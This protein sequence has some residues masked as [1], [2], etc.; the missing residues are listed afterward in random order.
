MS[1]QG[2]YIR[3]PT[4][5]SPL[6]SL[7]PLDYDEDIVAEGRNYSSHSNRSLVGVSESTAWKFFIYTCIATLALSAVNISYLSA[8]TTLQ[9]SRAVSAAPPSGDLKRPSVYLGLEN[10]VFEQSYC[11]TR[12]T[13]PKSFFTYDSR[14]GPHAQPRH[15]HA[16][17]DKMT[18]KFGG[19]VRTVVDFYVPDYGLENCTLSARR[20]PAHRTSESDSGTEA[21]RTVTTRAPG[22]SDTAVDIDVYLLPSPHAD[23]R[24]AATF[25]DTLA[26]VPGRES[27][28]KPFHCPGRAHVFLEWRCATDDCELV[29]PLEGVTSLS[30]FK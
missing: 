21:H 2:T 1:P 24:A 7:E 30:E 22:D 28:S 15:V 9:T 13:F 20:Y 26:F 5:P 19:P 18:L 4:S 6:G 10:V 25:L 14:D 16:P 29:I 3:L 12:G 27:T 17:D 11:R 8:S 23:D